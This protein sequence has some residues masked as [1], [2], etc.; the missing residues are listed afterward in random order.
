MVGISTNIELP[1]LFYPKQKG[2]WTVEVIDADHNNGPIEE[3]IGRR[4]TIRVSQQLGKPDWSLCKA[5]REVFLE[6]KTPQ[7]IHKMQANF[8]RVYRAWTKS[9]VTQ[10]SQFD[11]K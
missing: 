7:D 2:R 10:D 3:H 11:T 4:A 8:A 5:L 6:A 1:A 9:S